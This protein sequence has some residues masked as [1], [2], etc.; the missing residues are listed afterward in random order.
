MCKSTTKPMKSRLK[1]ST[2]VGPL[3]S[4][5]AEESN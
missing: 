3:W 5:G 1:T 2:V 4:E